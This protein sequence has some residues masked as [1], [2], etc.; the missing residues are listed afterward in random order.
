VSKTKLCLCL[1]L[2]SAGCA[3]A[4]TTGTIKG[5]VRDAATKAPISGAIVTIAGAPLPA[6]VTDSEGRFV[7]AGVPPGTYTLEA[8]MVGYT[9]AKSENELVIQD[10]ETEVNFLLTAEA[11]PEPT[12]RI[13][14]PLIRS[15]Q[16]PTMYVVSR[17]EEQMVR[18]WPDQLYQYT[19]IILGQPGAVPDAA[20]M[21]HVRGARQDHLAYMVDN[22]LISEPNTGEFG[23][24]LVTVGLDRLNLYTGG[25]RAE[26]GSALAGIAN[27]VIRTGSSIRGSRIETSGGSLKYRGTIFE[28]GNVTPRGLDWYVSANLWKS[29]LEPEVSGSSSVPAEIDAIAK[30]VQPIGERDKISFLY[31]Q[32]YARYNAFEGPFFS[33]PDEPPIPGRHTVDWNLGSNMPITTTDSTDYLKQYYG[34]ASLTWSRSLSASS[35]LSAQIYK[36]NAR[37]TI[38]ALSDARNSYQHRS[39]RQTG[40]RIDY[41]RELPTGTSFKSGFWI[42]PSNNLQALVNASGP[43][44]FRIRYRNVD[45]IDYALY[46]QSTLRPTANLT[47]DVGLRWDGRSYRRKPGTLPA[48]DTAPFASVPN[49]SF[50]TLSPRLGLAYN[51]GKN[52]VLRMNLGR[53]VQY[54]RA[55]LTL[56]EV[57]QRTISNGTATLE[58]KSVAAYDLRPERSFSIDIG[59]EHQFSENLAVSLTPYWRTA[60][61]LIERTRG[62]AGLGYYSVGEAS[63][64]G[65]ELKVTARDISGWSGWLSYTL[66]S[67]KGTGTLPTAGSIDPE[68]PGTKY[69]LPWDQRHTLFI[70]ASKRFGRWELNPSVEWGSGFPYGGPGNTEPDPRDPNVELPVF[71]PDGKQKSPLPNQ[72]RT[73]S[74]LNVSL[75]VRYHLRNNS[76]YYLCIQNLFNRR[77]VLVRDLY[78]VTGAPAGFRGDHWEYVPISRLPSRFVVMG[79]SR[80][81]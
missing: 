10:L 34:I 48:K 17:R 53:Y 62:P 64:R 12:V 77:D 52:T 41:N 8:S 7:I 55:S 31:N 78:D 73:G 60:R 22:I 70:T 15:Q 59:A 46:M 51:A 44:K 38:H 43:N 42:M 23:T 28:L 80:Q 19:G 36:Y 2:L 25:F 76:Y 21:P 24:N 20:G 27:G 58:R 57:L 26:Y 29:N 68:N 5:T 3:W 66:S 37:R 30:L 81:F 1:L 54:A 14:A 72:F 50:S 47:A 9:N 4:G 18:G 69:R 33:A 56:E 40:F 74:H 39:A 63:M 13:V 16:S 35:V 71:G 11:K 6:A 61:N 45:T 75:N 49:V 67:A 79:V 65:L 32:G